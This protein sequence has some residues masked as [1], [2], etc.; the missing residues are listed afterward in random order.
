MA[1]N[2]NLPLGV[3]DCQSNYGDPKMLGISKEKISYATYGAAQSI[4]S[5]QAL[6]EEDSSYVVTKKFSNL[7]VTASDEVS[8]ENGYGESVHVRN[9]P[10]SA[11]VYLETNP[12]DFTNYTRA[13]NGGVYYVEVFFGN[14]FKLLTQKSD[15]TLEPLKAQLNAIPVGMPALDNKH[16]QFKMTMKWDNI[17]QLQ[18]TVLVDIVD[19]LIDYEELMPVGWNNEWAS[20]YAAS[21]KDIKVWE[22]CETSNL[23]SQTPTARIIESNVDTP[24]V[25][26]GAPTAGVSTLTITKASTPVTLV[27]GDYIKFVLESKTGSVVD[28]STNEII[29]KV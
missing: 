1:C 28:Y 29:F 23:M 6:I 7:E 8:E 17:D 21:D 11:I 3:A 4:A 13:F 16:Q 9:T 15:G 20:A 22:R 27:A 5:V 25:T 26:A 18:N 24:A 14:G 12:C 2:L 10:G 19:D